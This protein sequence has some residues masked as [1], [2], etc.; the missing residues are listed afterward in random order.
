MPTQITGLYAITD[1]ELAQRD[2]LNHQVEAAIQGGA[3]IIQYRDKGNNQARRI[4]EA[5][6]LLTIC[7]THGV[8]LIIN[9]D[10]EL[11]YHIGADGIHLG[12]DDTAVEQARQRLGP[13]TIIG[14]SCYNELQ[15]AHDAQAAGADYA[16]FGRFFASTTKPNAIQA[17]IGLLQQARKALQIPI[18]AIGGI[19]PENGSQLVQAG[20]DMLAVIQ[21]IFAQPDIRLACH[22]FSKLF[23]D[24][25]T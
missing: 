8:L 2:G 12:R 16:A 11:A 4:S 7:R 5:T 1:Q 23:K 17:D 19:T 14:V 24:S 6:Q 22:E 15:C 10:L 20:A 25:K 21:G 18:V 9:D 3:R 13:S